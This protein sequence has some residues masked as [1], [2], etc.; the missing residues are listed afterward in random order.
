MIR[1]HAAGCES[2]GLDSPGR[3]RTHVS[4]DCLSLG[5]GGGNVP[6]LVGTI[7]TIVFAATMA[8][9][10]LGALLAR[11]ADRA[12]KLAAWALVALGILLA[13]GVL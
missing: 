5:L 4:H 12:G 8:G 7:G 10:T 6:V 2:P 13:V 11:H 9:L 1:P 3:D